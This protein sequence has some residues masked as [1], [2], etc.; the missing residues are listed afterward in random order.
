VPPITDSSKQ[1][2]RRF[3]TLPFISALFRPSL[4]NI[5]IVP[6]DGI[7]ASVFVANFIQLGNCDQ[8]KQVVGMTR[9][10]LLSLGEF[11]SPR[12]L[13][14]ASF[15]GTLHCITGEIIRVEQPEPK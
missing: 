13:R 7:L 9:L 10:H 6:K 5:P 12:S 2:P 15:K 14:D 8:L 1:F 11:T 3:F 4:Y